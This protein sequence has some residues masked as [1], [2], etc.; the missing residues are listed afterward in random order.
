MVYHPRFMM[1]AMR[2][3]ALLTAAAGLLLTLAPPRTPSGLKAQPQPA[4]ATAERNRDGQP[5][6]AKKKRPPI[7]FASG[8]PDAAPPRGC[9][10][11]PAEQLSAKRGGP[12][13]GWSGAGG[14]VG[15]SAG[16]VVAWDACLATGQNCELRLTRGQAAAPLRREWESVLRAHAPPIRL[17]FNS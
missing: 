5:S 3:V 9:A 7:A 14:H 8:I 6:P 4:R 1:R 16:Y 15:P 13:A 2:Q 17:E 11:E 12:N 10:H